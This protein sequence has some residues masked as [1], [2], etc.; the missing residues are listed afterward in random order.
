[1]CFSVNDFLSPLLCKL[2]LATLDK[3][4]ELG[5]SFL[6]NFGLSIDNF[7]AVQDPSTGSYSIQFNQNK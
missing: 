2:G 5:N 1:M 3:L 6:G 4:K 7:N